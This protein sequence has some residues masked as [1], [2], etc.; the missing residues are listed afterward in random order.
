MI[1]I[2]LR[3]EFI[4]SLFRLLRLRLDAFGLHQVVNL[5]RFILRQI[6]LL[7]LLVSLLVKQEELGRAPRDVLD[8]QVVVLV[9]VALADE[10][11]DFRQ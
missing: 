2:N 3:L 10:A 1:E 4:K 9:S 6:N 5:L 7:D 8:T 11:T